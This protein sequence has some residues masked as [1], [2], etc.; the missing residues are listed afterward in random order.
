MEAITLMQVEAAAAAENHGADPEEG[1]SEGREEPNASASAEVFY[2]ASDERP[3]PDASTNN[4]RDPELSAMSATANAH[5]SLTANDTPDAS[6]PFADAPALAA[7]N[8][9]SEKKMPP[10]SPIVKVSAPVELAA[11]GRTKAMKKFPPPYPELIYGYHHNDVLSGRGATIN[12]HPGNKLFR[13]MCAERLSEF[14]SA[15]NCAKRQIAFE[16]VE[17]VMM[18]WNPPGRFIERVNDDANCSAEEVDAFFREVDVDRVL[19]GSSAAYFCRLGHSL[20]KD[21]KLKREL[22]PWKDIGIEMAIQKAMS[23]IRD[24]R[25]TDRVAL[26]AMGMLKRKATEPQQKQ[27]GL[28][29]HLSILPHATV[30]LDETAPAQGANANDTQEDVDKKIF[31]THNDVLLGRGSF[32]N[33]YVGNCKFR[34]LALERKQQ[35]DTENPANR[36]ALSL[37]I[38]TLMKGTAVFFSFCG[39]FVDLP[40]GH[41]CYQ[42]RFNHQNCIPLE[43]F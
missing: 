19:V 37:E 9:K 18:E 42:V 16:I 21:R 32:I 33:E 8:K 7:D 10:I 22:G 1:E 25:R 3:L 23:V 34:S 39:Y 5:A 27:R 12:A 2:S 36:R 15:Q 11:S 24:H 20:K 31:P 26:R 17:I 43:G 14:E 40:T 29:P 38:V 6:I 35:F 13:S 28:Y 30:G 4:I 41:H